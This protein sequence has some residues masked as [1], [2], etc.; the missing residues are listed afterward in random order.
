MSAKAP[1]AMTK[2]ATKALIMAGV[3]TFLAWQLAD[4][5]REK[6]AITEA[7]R[8]QQLSL[9]DFWSNGFNILFPPEQRGVIRYSNPKA[10]DYSVI[11]ANGRTL[12][13]VRRTIENAIFVD[14]LL[15]RTIGSASVGPEE[16]IA[17]AFI[18][19]DQCAVCSNQ[20]FM[21]VAGRLRDQPPDKRDG[22]FLLNEAV[23]KVDP[24]ALYS[25]E[26]LNRDIRSLSVND[27]GDVVLYE[28]AGAVMR[29]TRSGSG[30][31]LTER[32]PGQFPT[33][34]P[35]GKA[36]LYVT[37]RLLMLA[38]RE[39]KHELLRVS[40]VVGGVRVSPDGN[41]VAF[42]EGT[43]A[44]G[45][46]SRLRICDLRTHMCIDGPKGTEWIAGLETFWIKR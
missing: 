17:I 30:W 24:I 46:Y 38:D 21:A 42:G 41:F 10:Y 33:L 34:M 11:A 32:H 35:N 8:A 7:V 6:R 26:V 19:V 31:T 3:V 9:A 22:V 2:T 1:Q 43:G 20:T 5:Q 25:S 14:T 40:S 18:N 29:Y 37:D 23:D 16:A 36:Y 45:S 15:K 28:D 13:A 44:A 27:G 39:G 4:G 12:F